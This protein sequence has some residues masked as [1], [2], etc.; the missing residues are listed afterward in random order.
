MK[1]EKLIYSITALI[2]VIS[3]AMNILHIPY[4]NTL[5]VL[6]ILGMMV[7]QNYHLKKLKARIQEME[8]QRENKS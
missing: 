1:Y 8:D 3:A 2:I 5:F 4:G 7:F 6:G